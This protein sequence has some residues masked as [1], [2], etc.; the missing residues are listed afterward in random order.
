MGLNRV[1]DPVGTTLAVAA[2]AVVVIAE[3]VVVEAVEVAVADLVSVVNAN[4]CL[5]LM[6]KS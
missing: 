5:V 6:A 3:A 4:H 1:S 2:E